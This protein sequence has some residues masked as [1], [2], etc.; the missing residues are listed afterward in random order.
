MRERVEDLG[1]IYE[2]SRMAQNQDCFTNSDGWRPY[3]W[4]DF[5]DAFFEADRQ[6]QEELLHSLTSALQTCEEYFMH[7]YEIASAQ[8]DLNYS[9]G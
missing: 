3:R 6:K 9:D 7:I 1:R 8:D 4:K 5:G 2:I